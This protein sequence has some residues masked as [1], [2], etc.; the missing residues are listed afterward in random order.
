MFG[1]GR[2]SEILTA[3]AVKP[4]PS[5]G[6]S[7]FYSCPSR[8]RTADVFFP[9]GPCLLF[10]RTSLGFQDRMGRFPSFLFECVCKKRWVCS[11]FRF[12]PQIESDPFWQGPTVINFPSFCS[13]RIHRPFLQ[14]RAFSKGPFSRSDRL[15]VLSTRRRSPF[16]FLG[17][18]V[19]MAGSPN[20]VPF[21]LPFP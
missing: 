21:R 14:Q 13:I 9:C 7:R 19:L 8:R 4:L 5:W 2:K 16:F 1:P 17:S 10:P 18:T 6:R 20:L 15:L 3:V 12:L 11:L